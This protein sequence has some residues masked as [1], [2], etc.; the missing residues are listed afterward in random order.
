MGVWRKSRPSVRGF[1]HRQRVVELAQGSAYRVL[2]HYRWYDEDRRLIRRAKRRSAVCR[3]PGP[4]P[5]LRVRGVTATPIDAQTARYAVQI[6][7]RG[8]APAAGFG[9]RLW[10][11]GSILNTRVVGVLGRQAHAQGLLHG[12]QL[13]LRRARRCRPG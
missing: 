7:N 4:L 6:A 8:S 9:V 2:V 11:D 3:Q 12:P 10:V 5:N 1:V 13:R